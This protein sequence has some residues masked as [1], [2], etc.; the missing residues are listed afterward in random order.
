[1]ATPIEWIP[2]GDRGKGVVKRGPHQFTRKILH[3]PYCARCGLM[4]LKN[5]VS[6]RAA[7]QPCETWEE[8]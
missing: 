7:K 2:W 1:M 6:R 4:A 8:A 3:W 5:D